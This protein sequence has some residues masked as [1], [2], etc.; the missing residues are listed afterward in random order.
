MTGGPT[1]VDRQRSDGGHAGRRARSAVPARRCA[2]RHPG[3]TGTIRP[4]GRGRPG[5]RGRSGDPRDHHVD[6]RQLRRRLDGQL[7]RQLDRQPR[8]PDR[9]PSGAGTPTNSP[10]DVVATYLTPQERARGSAVGPAALRRPRPDGDRRQPGRQPAQRPASPRPARATTSILTRTF[11]AAPVTNMA[12]P[13]S[14]WADDPTVATTA[15][16]GLTTLVLAAS[17]HPPTLAHDDAECAGAADHVQQRL[18]VRRRALLPAQP[19]QQRRRSRP[20]RAALPGRDAGHR[21]RTAG[22]LPHPAG[23][24]GAQLQPGPGRG[25]AVLHRRRPGPLDHSRPP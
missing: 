15:A 12:W 11:G 24:G 6:A 5:P 3:G 13:A 22:A 17:S 25:P 2:G 14:G 10:A 1:S 9:I 7:H 21:R 19:D 23:L 20:E 18:A 8:D 16:A 4:V